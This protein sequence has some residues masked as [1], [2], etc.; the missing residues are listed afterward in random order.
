MGKTQFVEDAILDSILQKLDKLTKIKSNRSSSRKFKVLEN[1]VIG[2]AR[3]G[4]ELG[5]TI[6]YTD[7]N[8][9]ERALIMLHRGNKTD[10]ASLMFA[11]YD[12]C[13]GFWKTP[14]YNEDCYVNLLKDDETKISEQFGD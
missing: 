2:W 3:P 5:C 14:K 10:C 11:R 6:L 8:S 7:I 12:S 13:D 9:K 4:D 1:D